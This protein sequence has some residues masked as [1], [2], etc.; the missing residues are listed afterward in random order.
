M[1]DSEH[2]VCE[3]REISETEKQWC[4]EHWDA[5]WNAM[6]RERLGMTN[7][8]FRTRIESVRAQYGNGE[9]EWSDQGTS[10]ARAES[11]AP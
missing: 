10:D 8:E 3:C 9:D 5:M 2:S 7:D 11:Q 4:Q 6:L 1:S